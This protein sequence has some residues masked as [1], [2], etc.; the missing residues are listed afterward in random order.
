MTQTSFALRR[1]VTT[2]MTFAA[3]AVIGIVAA[4]LL[5]PEQC[6]D[7]TFPFIGVSIP[8]HGSTPV[9]VEELITRPVDD[10]L[11]TL[12]KEIRPPRNR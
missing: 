3:V 6:P 8:Y 4:R 1:G 5:P 2:V 9:K 10:A 12:S 11:A 7:V